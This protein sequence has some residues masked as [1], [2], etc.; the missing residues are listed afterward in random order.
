MILSDNKRIRS[1][2]SVLVIGG[3]RT[4]V[5]LSAE[6]AADYPEKKVTLVH[7]GP[8]LVQILG[9]KA[10]EKAL[11]WL[12]SKGVD[13]LLGHSIDL[14]AISEGQRSFTTSA[15]ATITADCH[16]VCAGRPLGSSWL[17]HTLLKDN[18]DRFGRLKVDENLRVR[19]RKN[20][21]AIGDVV[22]LPEIK[23]GFSARKHAAVAAKNMKLLLR[24]GKE[25]KMAVYKPRSAAATPAVVSLG[26]RQAVAQFP[27]TTVS[28]YIPGLFKSKDLYVGWNRRKLGLETDIN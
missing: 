9:P 21:F 25:E 16:F 18:L 24:G 15:G 26:R 20:V 8:R 17:Q 3:G 14:D 1:S 10:S 7:E 19:G 28:G 4:G 27:F 6:I 2:S 23:Q 11:R 5:E 22:D 13:V 12:K